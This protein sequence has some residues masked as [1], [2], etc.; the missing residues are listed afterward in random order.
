M[1]DVLVPLP[2][3]TLVSNAVAQFGIKGKH[4]KYII[5]Q[6]TIKD[7]FVEYEVHTMVTN[8]SSRI[9]FLCLRCDNERYNSG[10][11]ADDVFFWELVLN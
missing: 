9:L 3:P 2:G 1:K 4:I 8:E 7:R 5:L 6:A 10:E 11:R